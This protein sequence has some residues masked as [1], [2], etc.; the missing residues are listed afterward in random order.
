MQDSAV[1][2]AP[3][4]SLRDSAVLPASWLSLHSLERV[5]KSTSQLPR[6]QGGNLSAKACGYVAACGLEKYAR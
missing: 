2:P 1:L 3:W 4:L 6:L 5:A